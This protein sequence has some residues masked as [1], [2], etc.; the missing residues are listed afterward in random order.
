MSA[1][2]MKKIIA[3]ALR[4][5]TSISSAR[6]QRESRELRRL[7]TLIDTVFALAIIMIVWDEPSPTQSA[8]V[9][10]LG[11]IAERAQHMLMAL[12]GIVVVLVYWFQSNLLLGNLSRTD[13][14]H[15]ILSILQIF[16]V[17]VYLLTVS[18]G[19]DIGNEP[20]ILAMQSIAAALVGLAAACAWW[21]ASHRRR[22]L[23]DET[24]D[25][26]VS[27][28]RLRVLAE[29]LTALLTVGLAFVSPL[30]WELGWLTYPLFVVIL[31][32]AG[33]RQ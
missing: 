18:Y 10:L 20:L 29:P 25:S 21:Y 14:K 33:I 30:L 23:T 17:L 2:R 22:L 5:E 24:D 28:L 19:I 9:D 27:A 12:I 32:R 3:N 11:F 7:E 6:L 13:P 4:V 1:A 26:D 16:M 15:A 8:S 31:Q